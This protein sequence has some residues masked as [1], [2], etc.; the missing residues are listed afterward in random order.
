MTMPALFARW[1]PVL[2]ACCCAVLPAAAADGWTLQQDQTIEGDLELGGGTLDLNGHVLIVAG[3]LIQ[4]A[5]LLRV[6]GGSLT[7]GG[8]YRIETPCTTNA[9][10]YC[11]SDGVLE[12]SNG[13]DRVEVKGNFV[14][15]SRQPSVLSA[16]VLDIKRN[17]VQLYP[18]S[19]GSEANFAASGSHLTRL[20]G[21][22]PQTV[23]FARPGA[24]AAH[25]ASLTLR[26]SSAVGVSFLGPVVATI[27]FVSNDVP[28]TL[29]NPAQSSLPGL[30]TGSGP[31]LAIVG[32]VDVLS[33]G[34]I[35][36]AAA[37]IT[38]G[39]TP[40]EVVPAWSVLPSDA[41]SISAD[42]VLDAAQV[43]A[44]TRVA[45][46]ARYEF[47]GEALTATRIV[48]IVVAAPAPSLPVSLSLVGPAVMQGGARL[49]LMAQ[50]IFE[51]GATRAVTPAWSSSNPT[52][53]LVGSGGV[54]FAGHVAS[55]TP[56]TVTARYEEN[57]VTVAATLDVTIQPSEATLAELT[58][59][60]P[61][62]LQSGG[63][64][65]LFASATYSDDSRR[66]LIPRQWSVSDPALATVD[67]RGFI[68]VGAVTQDTPLT[69]TATHSEGGIT[70]TAT[71]EIMIRATGAALGRL[72]IV[73]ARGVI[74][75]GETLQLYAEGRY[76][77]DSRRSATVTW[78][79]SRP[80]IA[81]ITAA[82]V[83]SVGSVAQ[84]TPLLIAATLT[85]G[86]VTRRAEFQTLVR[87]TVASRPLLAEVEATGETDSYS[88]SLWFNT[89][90]GAETERTTRSATTYNLYV[91]ALVPSGPLA[92]SPTYFVLNR[93]GTWETLAW[94]L[95]EYLSGVEEGSWE[96]V[97]LIESFDASLISGTQIYVGYG[98]SGDE[99]LAAGRYQLAYQIP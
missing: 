83:L 94:P 14:V 2:L 6:N 77:D 26:N 29:A 40:I 73:G 99:M 48:T 54:I 63:R 78:S 36:L 4:S 15:A 33:G 9:A 55:A 71:H 85:E 84:D 90:A 98:T 42:G 10:G 49:N 39:G 59:T 87:A 47:R 93:A 74:A 12:M 66:P 3:R 96:L 18:G 75:A 50:A 8:D 51:D 28:F 1:L 45:V 31:T 81:S 43:A 80:E 5:G 72:T 89:D 70:V 53:A 44:D 64:A 34:R 76:A 13:G 56:V 82:G 37:V 58:V 21:S 25:F 16:G 61:E 88:L 92:A 17:F 7:V 97:E 23:F 38:A 27:A 19:E 79:V 32:P 11:A 57:G 60:G 46:S 69:V 20:S 30:A 67:A 52:A 62:N 86:T 91:A 95:A 24:D 68:K 22:E 65:Q 35:G 41:A